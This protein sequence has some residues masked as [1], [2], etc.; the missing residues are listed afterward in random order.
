MAGVAEQDGKGEAVGES[1]NRAVDFPGGLRELKTP[2]LGRS[3]T[4]SFRY[5]CNHSCC[6]EN[7][8]ENC[9][10]YTSKIPL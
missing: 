3:E 2:G 9:H 1:S 6:S 7:C 8:T 4:N 5:T 10:Y